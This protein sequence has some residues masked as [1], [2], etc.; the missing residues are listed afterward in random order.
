MKKL[1][2]ICLVTASLTSTAA[3]A[4]S[5]ERDRIR[6]QLEECAGISSTECDQIRERERIR[7]RDCQGVVSDD[8]DRVRERDGTPHQDRTHER[9][10][11]SGSSGGSGKN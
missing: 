8:C 4:Q 10:G 7:L 3:E 1:L 5:Q 9:G 11:Q 2:L 6:E